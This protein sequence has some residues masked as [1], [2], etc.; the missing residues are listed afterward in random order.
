MTALVFAGFTALWTISGVLVA[1]FSCTLP[2][3]WK[4]KD[5]KCLD[6]VCWINYVGITNIVVEVLLISIPL[7]LWNLRTS[8]GRRTFVSLMFLARLGYVL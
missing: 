5:R 2:E 4:H 3:P 8:A 6:I 1:S 7:C